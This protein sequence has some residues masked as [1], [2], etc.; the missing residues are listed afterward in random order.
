VIKRTAT[1]VALGKIGLPLAVCVAESGWRVYGVDIDAEVVD[2]VNGGLPPFPN[3]PGLGERLLRVVASGSL[4]ATTD[5][6]DAVAQSSAV[7]IVV[8]LLVDADN[9]P[10]FRAVDAATAAVGAAV[11]A[12]TLVSFETTLPVGTTRNRLGPALEQVSGL[13]LGADLL[14]CHSPERVSSG[15][16][17]AGLRRYPKLVGGL[18]D[19]SAAAAVAFYESVLRFDDRPDL[20]PKSNGVWDVGSAEVAE[21]AKLADTTYRDLNIAFANELAVAADEIGVDVMDVIEASNSQ[22]FSHIHVPGVAVGGHC[23]PVYPHLLMG[24]TSA[25]RL[26]SVAREINDGMPRYGIEL[27]ERRIGPLAGCTVAILGAAYRGGV[28]EVF[29]SGVWSLVNL[30]EERGAHVRVH[31]P[32]FSD[33]ELRALGFTPF[34]FGEPCDA[35]V[36]QAEHD[37]YRDLGTADFPGA[38][39]VVDG[40]R[41][42][43]PTGWNGVVRAVIGGGE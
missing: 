3:E 4:V 23:I 41:V 35:V 7:V 22:P 37:D 29:R 32:L 16:V 40:R 5:T 18:D 12:G 10:D 33:D 2:S 36:I 11:R 42:T 25:R 15:L 39:I 17:F 34:R 26:A 1:V 38:R 21:F 43:P 20:L 27:I 30:L 19:A 28:K 9:Q 13:R 6:A 24:S 14:V 31:D 8:P